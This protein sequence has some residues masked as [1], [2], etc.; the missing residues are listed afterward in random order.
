M[1]KVG[2]TGGIGSGK[3]TASSILAKLGTYVFD[4]DAE[5]KI[6]LENNKDVQNNIIEEFG[7]D[8]LDQNGLID[9]AK[10]AKIAFQDEDHQIILNSIIH[11]FVFS[12]LDKQFDKILIQNKHASFIADGALIFESGLDQHLDSVLLIASSLK[13]RIARALNRGTLSREDIIRRNELQWTDEDKAESADYTIYN[14]GTEKEFIEKIK[15]FHREH[16]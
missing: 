2:L 13:Y 8:I 5:A 15:I 4:A 14:N 11:P 6:I 1:L 10:L 9:N 3:S 12:E 7:N 16:L